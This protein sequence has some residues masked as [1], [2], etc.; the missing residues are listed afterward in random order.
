M[1]RPAGVYAGASSLNDAMRPIETRIKEHLS[2]AGFGRESVP[3]R[4]R[5]TTSTST[6]GRCLTM[7]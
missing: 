3:R 4:F 6:R 1:L 5:L 2:H 7:R